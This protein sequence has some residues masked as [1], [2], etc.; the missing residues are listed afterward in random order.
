MAEGRF[1]PA[2]QTCTARKAQC[3]RSPQVQCPDFHWGLVLLIGFLTC[4]LFWWAWWIVEGVFVR[5]LKS[6]SK[7]LIFVVLSFVCYFAGFFINGL[8][9]EIGRAHV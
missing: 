7:A 4:G 9:R 8:M 1:T 2:A 3:L 6:D 5:K